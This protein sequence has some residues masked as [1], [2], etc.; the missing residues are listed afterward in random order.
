M[1]GTTIAQA[2]PLAISPVLTRLY[3][4]TQFGV[5]ALFSSI[6]MVLGAV[7]NGRY[8]LAIML[9]ESE[10][11][12]LNVA[13]L[14]MLINFVVSAVLLV[15]ITIWGDEFSEFAGNNEI[16]PWLYL[17]PVAVL[18]AGFFNVLNYYNTRLKQFGDL[19]KANVYKALILASIQLGWGAVK[20]GVVGL[21]FG[22][23]MAGAG[24]NIRL[25]SNV[26]RG[27]VK[28]RRHISL[29][30]MSR[31]AK[32]FAAFPKYS[33]PASF[34]NTLSPNL[35][36]VLISRFYSV[37]SLGQYALTQRVLGMPAA[38]LGNAVGQVFF[39]QASDERRA[40]GSASKAFVRTFRNL[41]LLSLP[42]FT[43]MYFV[44]E[45]LFAVVFGEPWREAGR[46]AKILVPLFAVRFVV[47]P[48]SL[49]TQISLQN[50]MGLIGNTIL[51]LL[52]AVV[53][54]VGGTNGLVL[55]T[56]LKIMVAV[57]CAFYSA[58]LALIYR[59][60]CPKVYR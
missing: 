41:A 16:R 18:F 11:D 29:G 13:V 48:L 46:L 36:S 10:E 52:T 27:E 20:G 5:F 9:P 6:V 21:I 49:M 59:V 1:T 12:A 35:A 25:V 37:H 57:L 32:Q 60:T 22:Q 14:G 58:Y 8:E 26:L 54:W 30:A 45:D 47:S 50:K 3:T 15:L 56:V 17:V 24:A 34:A 38:L 55:T 40:T 51:L 33:L 39:Q 28:L 53:L 43:A 2:V 19:A 4:P 42:I 44:V 31:N 7:A 23:L